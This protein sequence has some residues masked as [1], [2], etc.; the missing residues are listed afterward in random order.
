[1]DGASSSGSVFFESKTQ[2]QHEVDEEGAAEKLHDEEG[3]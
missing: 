3:K 1:M 2:G